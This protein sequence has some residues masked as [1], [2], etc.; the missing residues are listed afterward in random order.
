[1]SRLL[2]VV[3]FGA[4]FLA[5]PGRVAAQEAGPNVRDQIELNRT[6][7]EQKR[8]EILQKALELTTQQSEEFWPVYHDYENELA[9]IGDEKTRLLQAY[10]RDYSNMSEK[11]A[12]QLLNNWFSLRSKQLGI[13]K[14]Y[15]G[16]FRK[17]LPGPKVIRVFQMETLMDA[18]VSANIQANLPLANEAKA[19]PDSAKSN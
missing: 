15:Q 6:I 19:K 14:K 3:L 16:N 1:M 17:V 5:L 18:I 11:Q 13:Q 8:Q 2:V 7:I 10:A 9:K 4:T 12:D